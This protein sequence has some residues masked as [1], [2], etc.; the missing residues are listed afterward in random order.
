MKIQIGRGGGGGGD[1]G[2]LLR[3]PSDWNSRSMKIQ[4]GRAG[5]G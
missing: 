5:G 1:G 3:L 2:W 4:I